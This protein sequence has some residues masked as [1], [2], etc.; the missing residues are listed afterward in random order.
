MKLFNESVPQY[1][2][3]TLQAVGPWIGCTVEYVELTEKTETAGN[4]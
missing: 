2:S 4:K 3:F 1:V